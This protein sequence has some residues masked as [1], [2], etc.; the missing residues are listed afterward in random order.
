MPEAHF[1]RLAGLPP[2]VL[3][4]VDERKTAL[5]AAGED[6]FDFGLGNPDRSAPAEVLRRLIAEVPP[7]AHHRYA[8]SP[9]IEVLRR[10]ICDWYRRRYAVEL[11]PA[12]EAVA[13]IGSKEGLGHLFL[14]MLG[15]GDVALVPD[16]CYPIH[17]FGVRFAGAEAVPVATGPGFDP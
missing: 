7:A 14:A 17:Y 4:Q 10:A 3:A 11:D 6:I 2:Y 15:P 5:R 13:T 12:E 8:P 1:P 9:G 16:P